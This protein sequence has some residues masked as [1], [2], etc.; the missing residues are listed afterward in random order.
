MAYGSSVTGLSGKGK[1]SP[2]SHQQERL[3]GSFISNPLIGGW[4]TSYVRCMIGESLNNI[5]SMGG[6]LLSVTTDGFCC[7][8]LEASNCENNDENNDDTPQ[9]GFVTNKDKIETRMEAFGFKDPDPGTIFFLKSTRKAR[10]ELTKAINAMQTPNDLAVT[11][12]PSCYELKTSVIGMTQI[13]TRLQCSSY[14]DENS[15]KN[16]IAAMTGFSRGGMTH[17]QL[18]EKVDQI[19]EGSKEFSFKQFSLTGALD[20]YKKGVQCT[21]SITVKNLKL[22]YDQRRSVVVPE[23]LKEAYLNQGKGLPLDKMYDT[24]PY[25]TPEEST[26]VRGLMNV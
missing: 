1:Y 2:R 15:E 3:V 23:E 25:E 11:G 12:D 20:N 8:G 18:S 13:S 17:K 4:I 5:N 7:S 19:Y 9:N 26:L 21:P 16:K 6:R 22:K 10:L 14:V 24:V